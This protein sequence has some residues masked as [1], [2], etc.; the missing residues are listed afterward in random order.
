MNWKTIQKY[1]RRAG[2][3]VMAASEAVYLTM[4]D[5]SISVTQ[6]ALL[7]GALAYLLLPVDAVPDFLPGGY[8]DDISI[9]LTSLASMGK[10][11]KQ[12]LQECR[13]KY[14]LA[15]QSEESLEELEDNH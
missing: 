11:G 13:L 14:G 1:S 6:K 4:K 2:K 5:P 3:E 9:L 15:D 12:H 7:V 10:V 8:A